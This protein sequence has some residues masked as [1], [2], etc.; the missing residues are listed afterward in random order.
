MTTTLSHVAP[1]DSFVESGRIPRSSVV[2][3]I[4]PDDARQMLEHNL[5]NRPVKQTAVNRYASD[6]VAGAWHPDEGTPIV[7]DWNGVLLQGQH[8]L[9]AC[10]KADVP[11]IT[12]VN[13]GADPAA[14][15]V[16]D[17]TVTRSLADVLN[18]AGVSRTKLIASAFHLVNGYETGQIRG[19]GAFMIRATNAV[20][21]S[22]LVPGLSDYERATQASDRVYG[23]IRMN[24]SAVAAFYVLAMRANYVPEFIDEFLDG[25]ATG[26]D[27]SPG[28]ARL[29][30][31]RWNVLTPKRQGPPTLAALIRAFN[32]YSK[33]Q[34][35]KQIRSYVK[36]VE[37]PKLTERQKS[38]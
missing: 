11:F 36:G 38:A 19:G 8:R 28:D 21:L 9:L 18:H 10:I 15:E 31:N 5:Q 2:M 22:R 30:L 23:A 34:P 32:A 20:A 26:A 6:M 14:Y 13:R 35:L 4:T 37:F 33:G 7:F 25:V 29:A 12:R 24:Q 3:E 16:M 27:L 17:Q 1:I